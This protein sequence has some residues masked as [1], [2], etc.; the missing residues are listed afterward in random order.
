MSL[1]RCFVFSPSGPDGSQRTTWPQWI[2]CKY[3]QTHAARTC[4]LE[5]LNSH[6]LNLIT[7]M[8][9]AAPST[10]PQVYSI[11]LNDPQNDQSMRTLPTRRAYCSLLE[12]N[13]Y[14]LPRAHGEYLGP[15]AADSGAFS[16]T[17][18]NLHFPTT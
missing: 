7:A 10:C 17:P 14:T 9:D 8:I 13:V 12:I 2:T 1:A 15:T 16:F 18:D 6:R 3:L 11:T 5:P 4:R